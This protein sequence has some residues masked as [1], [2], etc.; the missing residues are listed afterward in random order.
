LCEQLLRSPAPQRIVDVG[1]GSGVI[2]VSLALGWPTVRVEGVDVSDDALSL[3]RENAERHGISDRVT[4]YR[5]DLLSAVEGTV[6]LIVANLPYIATSEIEELSVEVRRDP[7]LALDGGPDG[8][9]LIERLAEE[10]PRVLRGRLALEIGH[11]QGDSA[12]D[13]LRVRNFQDIQ[14]TTDY[15]GRQRFVFAIYG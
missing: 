2:A 12:I 9:R 15:Q 1:T 6:D 14:V 5:S 7:H 10:A 8:L 11:G 4:F 13:L 3:A